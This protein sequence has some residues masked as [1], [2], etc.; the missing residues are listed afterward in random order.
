MMRL[1]TKDKHKNMIIARNYN[2]QER[3]ILAQ[4]IAL[5]TLM[6]EQKI[7]WF[8]IGFFSYSQ[9][10]KRGFANPYYKGFKIIFRTEILQI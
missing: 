9:H 8:C 2:S 3:R 1:A 6:L 5:I 10:G 7:N 4:L